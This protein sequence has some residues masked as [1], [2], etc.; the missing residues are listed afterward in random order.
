MPSTTKKQGMENATMEGLRELRKLY[1]KTA[2]QSDTE[3]FTREAVPDSVDPKKPKVTF[4]EHVTVIP[5]KPA[6]PIPKRVSIS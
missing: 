1:L 3:E 4:S 2:E 6:N 5:S